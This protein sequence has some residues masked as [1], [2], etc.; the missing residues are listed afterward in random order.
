MDHGVVD[1]VSFDGGQF[2]E[3]APTVR[4]HFQSGETVDLPHSVRGFP[5]LINDMENPGPARTC[6]HCYRI[7]GSPDQEEGQ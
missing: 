5:R 6:P 2:P 1:F 3:R 7:H 4:I